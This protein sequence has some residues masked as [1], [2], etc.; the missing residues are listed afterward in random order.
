MFITQEITIDELPSL[1]QYVDQALN[2]DYR[3]PS[4]KEVYLAARGFAGV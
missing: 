2:P 4:W 1:V 3:P